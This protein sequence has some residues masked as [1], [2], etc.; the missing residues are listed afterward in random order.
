MVDYIFPP[1]LSEHTKKFSPFYR[2]QL[3]GDGIEGP[4]EKELVEKELENY[5][6]RC[7]RLNKNLLKQSSRRGSLAASLTTLTK[8]GSSA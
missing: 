3:V 5:I 1:L 8:M 7:L 2:S 6:Q 4:N